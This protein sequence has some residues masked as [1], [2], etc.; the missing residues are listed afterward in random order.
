[1]EDIIR[2][3]KRFTTKRKPKKRTHIYILLKDFENDSF[4]IFSLNK[5]GTFDKLLFNCLVAL[6]PFALNELKM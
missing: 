1:M 3:Q 2:F 6:V 4:E 5:I